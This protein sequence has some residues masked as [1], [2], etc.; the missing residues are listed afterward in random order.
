MKNTPDEKIRE[1]IAENNRLTLLLESSQWK[2]RQQRLEIKRLHK[3]HINTLYLLKLTEHKLKEA[4]FVLQED[5]RR[6]SFHLDNL[7]DDQEDQLNEFR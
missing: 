7:K 2:R 1:L 4:Q 3:A 6:E 5:P